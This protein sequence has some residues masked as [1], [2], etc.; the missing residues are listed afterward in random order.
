MKITYEQAENLIDSYCQIDLPPDDAIERV[1]AHDWN[2]GGRE[3]RGDQVEVIPGMYA[4]QDE[5]DRILY[6][7]AA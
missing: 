5:V 2:L 7:S 3:N 6:G 1:M 4:R